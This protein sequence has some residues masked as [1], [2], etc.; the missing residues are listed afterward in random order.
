MSAQGQLVILLRPVTAKDAGPLFSLI[1]QSNITDTI[2][3]DGPDSLESF[4]ISL[5]E[6]A[7]QMARGEVHNFTIVESATGNQ[8]GSAS[9]RPDA[10]F[11]RASVGLWIGAPYQNQ[12]FG[13]ATIGELLEY[14]FRQLGLEKIEADVFVGNWPSRRIFEKN[15]F[16]LEGTIRKA[17]RKRGSAVDEWVL[18]IT[19]EDWESPKSQTNGWIVHI[20]SQDSWEKAKL[21][22]VYQPTSLTQEGFIHCSRP[23]QVLQVANRFYREAPD[24]VMLW[25]DPKQL[26]AELQWEAAEGELFPHVYGPLNLQSVISIANFN[27]GP[28]GIFHDLPQP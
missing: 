27:P 9:I 1:D 18:G 16:Q 5:A 11:F 10:S 13:T 19:R 23:N 14:G 8:I 15:G 7:D 25:I 2:L 20:C 3:W 22:G 24:L 21:D 6:R 17:V 4:Q 28:D 12:G 26:V